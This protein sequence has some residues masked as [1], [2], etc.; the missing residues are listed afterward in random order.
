LTT[1]ELIVDITPTA[2]Q[3]M[4]TKSSPTLVRPVLIVGAVSIPAGE[5]QRKRL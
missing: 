3:S 5:F 4:S 1:L 2:I